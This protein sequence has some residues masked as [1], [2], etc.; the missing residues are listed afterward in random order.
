VSVEVVERRLIETEEDFVF[1]APR[2][3]RSRRDVVIAK[4]FVFFVSETIASN[5]LET[6]T[7]S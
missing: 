1:G 3:R 7:D 2:D 5:L 6:T 4:T